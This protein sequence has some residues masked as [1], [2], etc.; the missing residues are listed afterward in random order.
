MLVTHNK[1]NYILSVNNLFANASAKFVSIQ[2][3]HAVPLI[4]KEAMQKGTYYANS[5]FIK[6]ISALLDVQKP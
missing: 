2:T 3:A 1:L 6:I 5:L 4:V